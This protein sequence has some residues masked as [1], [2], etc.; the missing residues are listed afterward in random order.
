MRLHNTVMKLHNSIRSLNTVM[1]LHNAVMRLH[2]AVMRLHN[3]VVRLLHTG[4]RLHNA[5][6]LTTKK[7]LSSDTHQLLTQT[8]EIL[9]INILS[10]SDKEGLLS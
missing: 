3:A 6:W 5:F 8:L 7:Q 4:V 10:Q 9:I 1:K 2:N